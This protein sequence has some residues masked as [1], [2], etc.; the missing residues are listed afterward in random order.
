MV[1]VHCSG[2]ERRGED[3]S[4]VQKEVLLLCVFSFSVATKIFTKLTHRFP[5]FFHCSSCLRDL[6]VC[7]LYDM[8]TVRSLPRG[9]KS[10]SSLIDSR[11]QGR[12]HLCIRHHRLSLCVP[13]FY[14]EFSRYVC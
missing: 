14:H 7:V 8:L 6:C 10:Q 11:M 2:I 1:F 12:R 13:W 4:G 3:Y 5:A 9:R